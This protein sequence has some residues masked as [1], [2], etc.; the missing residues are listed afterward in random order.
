MS[1]ACNP[2]IN[3]TF[4]FQWNKNPVI[5]NE[6]TSENSPLLRILAVIMSRLSGVPNSCE[7]FVNILR[8]ASWSRCYTLFQDDDVVTGVERIRASRLWSTEF[9]VRSQGDRKLRIKVRHRLAIK[10]VTCVLAGYL[11]TAEVLDSSLW[12]CHE[13]LSATSLIYRASQIYYATSNDTWS[14]GLSHFISRWA[15][16]ILTD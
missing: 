15:Y 14:L 6:N 9:Y 8:S 1:H 10:I 13:W 16:S 7:Y 4:R 5:T 3:S 12:E 2:S 11:L